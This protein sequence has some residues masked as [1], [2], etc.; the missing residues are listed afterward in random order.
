MPATFRRALGKEGGKELVVTLLDGCLAAYPP[1]E[2]QKL[3]AQLGALP[4]F[5]KPV[6]ALTRLL[7][8]RAA[9]CPL[10]SQGR[11]LLP[12]P[13]RQGAGLQV[14]VV[15]V[16]VL[17]RFELWAPETWEAFVHDSERMLDD[18]SL[19]IP[20]PLPQAGQIPPEPPSG[21]ARPQG[22]PRR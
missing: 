15:V 6:K 16:G 7:A 18:V 12:L 3:E 13:L 10:D 1:E 19:D 2:W 8:S 11:I 22:K 5:S 17:N 9:D 4:S 20:W 14:E 21:P